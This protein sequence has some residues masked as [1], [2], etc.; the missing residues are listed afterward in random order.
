MTAEKTVLVTGATGFI[1]G[2]VV[3]KLLF[4]G[5]TKVKALVRDYSRAARLARFP[6][7]MVSGDLHDRAS[8]DRATRDCDA[9]LHCAF[10]WQFAKPN[11]EGVTNLGEA[12]LKNGVRR[13][14]HV[15]T[16]A[17][18][19]PLSDGPLTEESLT[20][21]KTPYAATKF[22]VE[23]QMLQLVHSRGV[24]A[25]IL[26]PTIVY[27]PFSKGWT[28]GPV[29]NLLMGK[30]VLPAEKD[31]LCNA[32]YVDD[33]VDAILLAA[34]AEGVIGERF[35]ISG[36]EPV[37]WR[38]FYGAYARILGVDSIQLM[39]H[40]DI[41][42]QNKI[43]GITSLAKLFSEPGVFVQS[44]AQSPA[45]KNAMMQV[46]RKLGDGQKEMIKRLYFYRKKGGPPPLFIPNPQQLDLYS[47][48]AHVKIDKAR[49]GLG[50]APRF[51]VDKGMAV[52]ADYIRWAF[53]N[54]VGARAP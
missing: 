11:L 54:G 4:G 1:G 3:E 40:K 8:L 9:V 52:T 20:E 26:Q 38:E 5:K 33:C 24:P 29:Q 17:V 50:Y 18:Y 22:A 42:H 7:E 47:A 13:L 23:K 35:L 53:P 15:S 2:R 12:C 51:P 19:E 49:N 39:P 36:P 27:G 14:V 32:V 46:Y 16:M 45:I 30:L 28:D 6:V 44:L 21:P 34:E 37:S 25:V 48:R 43:K 10:D 41:V 31:G